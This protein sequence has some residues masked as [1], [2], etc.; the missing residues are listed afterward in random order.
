MPER[1]LARFKSYRCSL[2]KKIFLSYGQCG[3]KKATK[4]TF[5]LA[6]ESRW[7]KELDLELDP[8]L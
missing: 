1:A 2:S 5:F 4:I 3:K 7:R 6:L 8:D